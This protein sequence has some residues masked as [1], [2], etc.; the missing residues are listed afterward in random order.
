MDKETSEFG[1][2]FIYNLILFSKH[3]WRHF[4]SFRRAKEL[5]ETNPDLW[6]NPNV[7]DLWFNGAGD[8]LF[9]LE[10]PERYKNTEI[11]K[12]AEELQTE[13]LDR[14]LGETT[15]TQFDDFFERLE[16]LAV[17]IDKDLG[18]EDIKADWS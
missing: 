5:H 10:I 16:K 7:D 8:H 12:L 11:G 13:G 15:K 3:W 14:R 1:K 18:L 17:L 2:G 6:P 4:E 9:E